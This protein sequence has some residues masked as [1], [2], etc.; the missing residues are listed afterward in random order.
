MKTALEL[1]GESLARTCHES[2]VPLLETVARRAREEMREMASARAQVTAVCMVDAGKIP[3]AIATLP[4]EPSGNLRRAP[5]GW[6]TPPPGFVLVHNAHCPE[7]RAGQEYAGEGCCT[8]V[9]GKVT[10][11]QRKHAHYFK[12]TPYAEIDIYRV[13]LLYGVTDPCLQEAAK[14]ILVAGGRGAKDVRKDVAEAVD[15]L[16]RWQ[17]MRTEEEGAS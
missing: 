5:D 6:P 16:V 4:L 7:M 11:G 9:N 12:A 2:V 15:A 1:I 10:S 8:P 14:K 17:E 3:A 13:L